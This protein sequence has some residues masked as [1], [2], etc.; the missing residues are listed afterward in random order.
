MTVAVVGAGVV[1]LATARAL[2]QRGE[3]VTVYE[4][5][6]LGHAR[7]SSHGKSRIFRLSYTEEHW[8]KF[9][10]RA[11]EL[12]RELERETGTQLLV[13]D[14]LIDV[15]PEPAG[16]LA[17]FDGC[18]IA[19]EEL[20]PDEVRKR[21]G[22]AYDDVERLVYTPDAG[23]TLADAAVD[24]LA[25]SARAAGAASHE[26]A[27]VEDLDSLP[28]DAIVVAAGGWAPR[29]LASAGIELTATPVRETVAYFAQRDDRV[30]PSVIDWASD[31][32]LQLYALRAP[33]VGVKVGLHHSGVQTDPDT[34]AGPDE[35]VVDAV[36]KLVGRR[37]PGV[38]PTPLSAE[39]CIYT[40][41]VD[42][43]FVCGRHGRIV[44]GSACSGHGFKFA[45]AVGEL[46]AGLVS[47]ESRK[48]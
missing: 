1:G 2:A 33:G 42:E 19:Y 12:W 15:D 46:L 8:I 9:A 39:T 10:Q 18:G 47:P 27:R 7:G 38:D 48:R 21:F 17:A 4:Q 20:S 23:I 37:F 24:A 26:H 13:L 16:R 45:P 14:G 6:A 40:N 35:S 28:H 3:E 41:T 34:E 29:L 32:D 30:F 31:G 36:A 43:N 5:F 22:F 25:R 11:Y 44:V